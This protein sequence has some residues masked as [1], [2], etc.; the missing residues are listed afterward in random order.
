MAFTE[1]LEQFF[2]TRDFAVVAV[3]TRGEEAVATV[4]VIFNCR[5]RPVA[6]YETEVEEP[7]PSLFAQA[8]EVIGVKRGDAVA[9]GGGTYVV[10]R[11]EPGGTGITKLYM[12]E[13]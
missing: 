10:E 7:Q 6:V 11:I 5:S 4:H 1:T 9:V 13:A 3:F 8:A 12:A 2:D